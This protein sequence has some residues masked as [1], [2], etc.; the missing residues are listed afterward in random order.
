MVAKL[1]HESG[2]YLGSDL[3]LMPADAHNADGYWEHVKFVQLNDEILN[4]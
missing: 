3:D 2:V 1:L 4:A